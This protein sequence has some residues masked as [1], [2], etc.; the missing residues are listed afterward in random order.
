[1]DSKAMIDPNGAHCVLTSQ[2]RLHLLECLIELDERLL[3]R[4]DVSLRLQTRSLRSVVV[5]AG[6]RT[7]LVHAISGER[8]RVEI[9]IA[10][11]SR[12]NAELT[13]DQSLA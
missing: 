8:D 10:R 3:R 11:Q 2:L 13:S 7:L 12:S 5:S 4:D 6:Q 1:M 9:V